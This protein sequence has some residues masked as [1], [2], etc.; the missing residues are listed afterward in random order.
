MFAYSDDAE[1][2]QKLLG[3][4]GGRIFD[5]KPYWLE[6]KTVILYRYR[7]REGA[8]LIRK[9]VSE[10]EAPAEKEKNMEETKPPVSPGDQSG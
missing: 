1:G 10:P 3:R 5:E 8:D 2:Q 4:S 6:K 9:E 7:T